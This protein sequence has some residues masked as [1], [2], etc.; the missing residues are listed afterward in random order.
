M[1][2]ITLRTANPALLAFASLL[3]LGSCQDLV[4]R[5]SV[6]KKVAEYTEGKTSSGGSLSGVH[7]GLGTPEALANGDTLTVAA[8][9]AGNSRSQVLTVT[10]TG[11]QTLTLGTV[12]LNSQSAAGVWALDLPATTTLA[13]NGTTT[14]TV[15]FTPPVEAAET[16]YSA[17]LSVSSGA[18]D[19]PFVVHL[20]G[21]GDGLA[22]SLAS[23]V[24]EALAT[25][26]SPQHP[27][28]FTLV[29]SEAVDPTTVNSTTV[30]LRDI[31]GA[32]DLGTVVT[33]A[34]D[35]KTV[36]VTPG[37]TV[38]LEQGN[39]NYRLSVS[40]ALRD[41][42]GNGPA[43][44]LLVDFQTRDKRAVMTHL[45]T[46]TSTKAAFPSFAS[47][48]LDSS[49]ANLVYLATRNGTALSYGAL[50]KL[51]TTVKTATPTV[52]WFT[53]LLRDT[54]G[55]LLQDST[56]IFSS[57]SHSPL[58]ILSKGDGTVVRDLATVNGGVVA[59]PSP[60]F[61]V[62]PSGS[63]LMG[64]D[65]N[66]TNN[67]LSSGTVLS[68]GFSSQDEVMGFAALGTKLYAGITNFDIFSSSRI[69]ALN[70]SGL[71][72]TSFGD[73][74][75]SAASLSDPIE[76]ITSVAA[77]GSTQQGNA[78]LVGSTVTNGLMILIAE[79]DPPTYQ[80]SA[81]VSPVHDIVAL[82]Q[83]AFLALGGNG[84]GIVDVNHQ[85]APVVLSL[86]VP[87]LVNGRGAYRIAI[88]QDTAD[89]TGNTYYCYTLAGS[90]LTAMD[91]LQIY[92]IVIQ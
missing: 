81:P 23:S 35:L 25:N 78:V 14:L 77:T 13:P 18:A 79:D 56:R 45:S 60:H 37:A 68:A 59:Q 63:D 48:L 22:P 7:L 51:N 67:T 30:K 39:H 27:K 62:V 17:N 90:G 53:E 66:T 41:E 71:P 44:P 42:V 28:V 40:T 47:L 72:Y 88:Q 8:T 4:L 15:W 2:R 86:D 89:T 74:D 55:T 6:E 29:F 11:S 20:S 9:K 61:F 80:T 75:L 50:A 34:A 31:D 49:N 65:Y 83:Y 1:E 19:S 21:R 43:S 16:L 91:Q 64:Y 82:G 76:E 5:D 73:V 58:R 70:A 3:V 57:A 84:I 52:V 46:F 87:T 32:F 54:P 33:L 24:P 26:V 69:S 92:K 12:A 85:T 36:S 10:N 38:D